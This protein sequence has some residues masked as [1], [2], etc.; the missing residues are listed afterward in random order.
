MNVIDIDAYRMAQVIKQSWAEAED[1][2]IGSSSRSS[3]Q[4]IEKAITGRTASRWLLKLGFKWKEV[5]KGVYNDGHERDDVVGYR[6]E[7]FLPFLK[8]VESRLM[9]WDENL[10]PIPTQLVLDGDIEALIIV[11]HDKYTFNANDGKRFVWTHEEHNPIRKKGRGQGLHVS[12]LLTPIGRLGGGKACEILKCGGDV[13]WDGAKLLEQVLTKAIPAFEEGFPGCQVLFMFDNAKSHIKYVEDALRV[14][15]MNLE[16]GGKNARPMRATFVADI[17]HPEGGWLQSLV[18]EDGTPK[19]LR[20][21]LS[22]R[23]LWPTTCRRFLTQCSIKTSSG[24]SKPNPDC[25]KGG[26]C[27]AWGLL[28]LQLDFEAQKGE[29]QE[30]IEKAG[31]LVLFYPPFHCEINFIEYFWEAAKR[32][33]CE[34]CEYDFPSLKRLVPKAMEQIPNQVI[35]KYAN[36]AKRIIKAYDTGAIYGSESYKSIVST[37][38]KSHRRVSNV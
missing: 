6:K 26:H 32:Y 29:Q 24:K 11:T 36:R 17:T 37:K 9:E 7:V 25:L 5:K 18:R 4:Q 12:E 14:S 13:W 23:N 28:A 19:G 2:V 20:T 33:T 31:H 16:D 10:I 38:Y 15:K 1:L 35:W 34:H 21:V 22:E 27:C 30:T 3:I 8:S